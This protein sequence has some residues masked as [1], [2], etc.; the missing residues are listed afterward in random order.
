MKVR[1]PVAAAL[2]RLGLVW[3]ALPV[4]S[5]ASGCRVSYTYYV[6]KTQYYTMW[7][8]RVEFESESGIKI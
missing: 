6:V 2:N 4:I 3:P 7:A 1:S 5:Q 8:E